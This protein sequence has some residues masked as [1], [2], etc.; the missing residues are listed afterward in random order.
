VNANPLAASIFGA[1]I[2]GIVQHK[3]VKKDVD[4]IIAEVDTDGMRAHVCVCAQVCVCS[5]MCVCVGACVCVCSR[6]CVRMWVHVYVCVRSRAC[7]RMCG[8]VYVCE[9]TRVR[10]CVL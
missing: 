1:T 5:R 4:C 6:V 3:I 9:L 10:M 7:V 2:A 8:C